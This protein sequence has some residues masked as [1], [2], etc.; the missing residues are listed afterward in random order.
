MKCRYQHSSLLSSKSISV[1]SIHPYHTTM[2]HLIL[3]YLHCT[4]TR[5][6]FSFTCRKCDSCDK[7]F[8]T[9]QRFQ[10]H[11]SI[12]SA[13]NYKSHRLQISQQRES[14]HA[15]KEQRW[16]NVKNVKLLPF[17]ADVSLGPHPKGSP[18]DAKEK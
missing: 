3:F 18:V 9:F 10:V 17:Q 11:Q 6:L 1:A 5:N 12:D 8:A 13:N 2:S 14:S 16:E 4:I 7:V 15:E